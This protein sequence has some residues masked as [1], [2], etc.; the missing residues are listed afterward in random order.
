M[1]TVAPL[2]DLGRDDVATAGGKAANLGELVRAGFPVPNGFVVT[3]EA[4]AT[5]IQPLDLNIPERNAAGEA[6]SIRA[7]IEGAPMPA[8]LRT[9]IAN[10]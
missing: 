4:Y 5:A 2:G 6:A 3:T 7:D 8:E 1:K 10:A 9:E